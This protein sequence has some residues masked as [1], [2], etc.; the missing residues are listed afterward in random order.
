MALDGFLGYETREHA[1]LPQSCILR[2]ERRASGL[3]VMKGIYRLVDAI[4]E[5]TFFYSAI[6]IDVWT[7]PYRMNHRSPRVSN[8]S[9]IILELR[10]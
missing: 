5:R 2:P 10:I 6:L 1:P 7:L 8:K 9:A 4:T 3:H